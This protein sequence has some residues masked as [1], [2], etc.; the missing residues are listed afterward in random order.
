[1]SE[2]YYCVCV[3][4]DISSD[5][6]IYFLADRVEIS[7]SGAMSAYHEKGYMILSIPAQSWTYIHGASVLSGDIV[8]SIDHWEFPNRSSKK[9]NHHSERDK[10]TQSLRY[11]VMK[12]DDFACV[13]CG[14]S[15]GDAV[16]L[17]VDHIIPV[18][19]GGK[20]EMSNLQT[21]CKACNRG[22]GVKMETNQ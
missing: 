18:S 22:K 7:P 15:N 19:K 14:K 9:T 8:T 6:E 10:M 3:S 2:Y 1:M 21:L 16:K 17:E 11:N 20:T 4:K 12:R 13:L 5:G